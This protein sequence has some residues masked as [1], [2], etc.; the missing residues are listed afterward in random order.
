MPKKDDQGRWIDGAG[1][2]IPP[3]Y[4]DPWNKDQDRLVTRLIRLAVA[5]SE[6]I[7]SLR[8]VS[9]GDIDKF[10][11]ATEKRYGVKVRTAG[12]N[13]TL[14]D[15]SNTLKIEIKVNNLITFDERLKLAKAIIDD[16]I[17]R[18]SEGS[19]DN[20]RALIDEAFKVDKKG[21]L[22]RERV[23]GLRRIKIRDKEWEKAM[24]I[25]SDSITVVGSKQYIRFWKKAESG[26]WESIPLDIA[27]G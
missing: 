17:N 26:S 1:N 10:M 18:W 14:T 22:D 11:T 3:K 20:L 15:F 21:N 16:C 25:I 23:L 4:I 24:G 8:D 2:A 9:F 6:K 5:V 27:W 12:G 7:S 19:N 13:K